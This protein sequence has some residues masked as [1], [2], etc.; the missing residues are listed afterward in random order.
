M[1]RF[2]LVVRNILTLNEFERLTKSLDDYDLIGYVFEKGT[3]DEK[4]HEAMFPSYEEQRWDKHESRMIAISEANPNFV[5]QLTIADGDQ[6]VRK[7]IKNGY[8]ETC[9]GEVVFECPSHIDWDKY[10]KF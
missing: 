8:G 7:Y 3:Y 10:L 5:F 1:K 2:S 6:Y 9:H 4:T